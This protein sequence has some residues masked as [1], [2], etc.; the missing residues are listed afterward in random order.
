MSSLEP[1]K[2]EELILDAHCLHEGFLSLVY[3]GV[4]GCITCELQFGWVSFSSFMTF[5][6][7]RILK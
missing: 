5:L 7:L 2:S 3:K 4:L 6:E 1:N